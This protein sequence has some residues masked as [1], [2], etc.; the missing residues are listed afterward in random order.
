MDYDSLY[1]TLI[2]ISIFSLGSYATLTLIGA[3]WLARGH[4]RAWAWTLLVSAMVLFALGMGFVAS[5]LWAEITDA[6][7]LSLGTS[8][9]GAWCIGSLASTLIVGISGH[10]Y[11]STSDNT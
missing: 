7:Y 8:I 11:Q 10:Q 9:L 5:V 2:A 1:F 4:R 6:T 3:R